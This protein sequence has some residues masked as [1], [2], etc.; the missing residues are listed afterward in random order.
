LIEAMRLDKKVSDGQIRFVLARRIGQVEPGHKIPPEWIREVVFFGNLQ[1]QLDG[2]PDVA[3][4]FFTGFA[5]APASRQG[6]AADG[7]AFIRFYQ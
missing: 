1:P 4:G 6:G 3:Q 5:L 7:E 2:L